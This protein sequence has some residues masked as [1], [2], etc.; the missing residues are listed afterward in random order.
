MSFSTY[1]TIGHVLRNKK[2]N[3][4]E[5]I[6]KKDCLKKSEDSF[7]IGVEDWQYRTWN[8][9]KRTN[10]KKQKTHTPRNTFEIIV[11]ENSNRPKH[12]NSVIKLCK[13]YILL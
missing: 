3:K 1:D 10:K 6:M 2:Q 11:Y 5:N 8:E 4:S 7:R 9:Q 13:Y 12:E